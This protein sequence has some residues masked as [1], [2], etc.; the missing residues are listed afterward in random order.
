MAKKSAP[1]PII[2]AV[3]GA[4]LLAF[5]A[6][7]ATSPGDPP[8]SIGTNQ[9]PGSGAQSGTA[10]DEHAEGEH[11]EGEAGHA[12]DEAGHA[13]DGEAGHGEEGHKE[14][15]AE[16]ETIVFE[17]D[18]AREAGIT[19]QTVALE[20]QTS[21]IP[22]NGQITTTPGGV[23]RVASAV[24]GRVTRLFVAPGD[25][26]RR[27]QTLAIVESRAIGEAQSAYAQATARFGNAQ[28]NLNVVSA[29]ARAGVFARAPLE[30]ARRTLADAQAEV[31]TQEIAVR[32]ARAALDNATRL[33][34][35][36]SYA[37][38]AL[39]AARNQ[40]AAAQES[41]RTAQAA[42]S[43]ASASVTSARA[44]L[45]RR[46]GLAAG[47]AYVSRPVQEARRSLVA[48]QSAR[49]A[50]QSE[51]ATT[52]ANLARARSLSA[53]GLVSTR[54]LEAAG[55]AFETATARLETG[56]ADE[57]AARQELERQQKLSTSNVAGLAEIGA[58]QSALAAAQSDVRTRSAEVIRARE[59]VRLAS[60]SLARERAVFGQGIA[61]RR[62]ISGASGG[63]QSAQSALTRARQT[64]VLAQAA[65]EREGRIF[66]QGL[67]NTAQVQA[68]RATF[69]GAQSDLN[70]ARTALGLLKSRPG[71][72]ASIPIT[73]PIDGTVQ[74]REVA[75]GEVLDADAGLLTLVNLNT[76]AVEAAI[77]EGSIARV[78]SGSQVK[79]TVAA[80]PNRAFT[81]QINYLASQLDPQTRTLTARALVP[82]GGGLRPG[83]FARGQ[84]VTAL[85]GA[86]IT[87]PADAIQ[88][89]EGEKMVFIQGDE[90]N[91][92]EKRA[93]EVGATQGGRALIKSGLK[94]GEKIVVTGAFTVKAQAMKAELGH[95]H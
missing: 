48:A 63:L 87:V 51:V 1:W 47:G 78:R 35:A 77:P 57:L 4:G 65:S 53:E 34:R 10:A 18:S 40:A 14:G 37:A 11:K 50:A 46:R 7:R 56:Q 89:L 79:L 49:A 94:A 36:G 69:V 43:G 68:A 9:T 45:A 31:R 12:E 82:G 64:L 6:G 71:G 66:R 24:P 81:G 5:M 22:F 44:E 70:A 59:G 38:P 73:A 62:E 55:Q 76:L 2:G 25:T 41:F 8:A 86:A 52:R 16:S 29:Q 72:A 60:L 80:V 3:A 30:T 95:G 23:V 26:V 91:H 15:E 84:I 39:E 42:L 85:A 90:A 20:A 28:S 32:Q 17:G 93:V 92:F 33:A 54:D 67:N 27:G 61:N 13:E 21:G 83:M 19:T 58:A 75:Q 88:D 74:T